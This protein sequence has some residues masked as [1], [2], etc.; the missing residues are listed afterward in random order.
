[1]SPVAGMSV[2]LALVSLGCGGSSPSKVHSVQAQQQVGAG[3]EENTP[4]TR[5]PL[6]VPFRYSGRIARSELVPVLDRG[7]GQ[8]L[9]GVETTPAMQSGKLVGF[10]LVSLYPKDPHFQELE[11]K[12]GDVIT[13]ING[14]SLQSPDDAARVWKELY[15]ASELVIDYAR[16]GQPHT[17]RF[18]I[19]D[20]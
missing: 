8:F 10:Q 12:R 6:Q 13:R 2:V 7:L 1:M 3:L 5:K 19:V 16:G 20:P 15:V 11:L 14:Q 9:R 17:L 4:A 18:E